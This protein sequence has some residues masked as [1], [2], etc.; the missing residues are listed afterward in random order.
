MYSDSED[1][2][3]LAMFFTRSVQPVALKL[4][5]V[6]QEEESPVAQQAFKT[7][8]HNVSPQASQQE[9]FEVFHCTGTCNQERVGL[10]SSSSS[11][12]QPDVLHTRGCSHACVR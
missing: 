3:S 5:R 2:G 10:C 12:L 1:D 4:A 7:V 9:H 11:S 8:E 6:L